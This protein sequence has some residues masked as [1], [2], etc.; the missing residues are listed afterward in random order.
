MRQG[1]RASALGNARV[2]RAGERVLAIAKFLL[3]FNDPA[4]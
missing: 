4:R 1:A 2:A 3:G